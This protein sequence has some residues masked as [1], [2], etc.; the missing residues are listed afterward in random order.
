MASIIQ[1]LVHTLRERKQKCP[2]CSH[3]F[4]N[5]T[6]ETLQRVKKVS[7]FQSLNSKSLILDVYNTSFD[8][9]TAVCLYQLTDIICV[10]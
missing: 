1:S 8:W 7:K 10:M 9:L 3:C 4:Y 2:N 6:T 5:D